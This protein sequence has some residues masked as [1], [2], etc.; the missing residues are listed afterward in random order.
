MAHELMAISITL[1]P[2]LAAPSTKQK[3][4]AHL[5]FAEQPFVFLCRIIAIKRP[6]DAICS[7]QFL[8]YFYSSRNIGI[9]AV[10][11]LRDFCFIQL[12]KG[13]FSFFKRARARAPKISN[14]SLSFQTNVLS[15]D[16]V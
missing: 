10:F 14:T 13:D 9:A 12:T 16:I 6:F 5:F 1:A 8:Q 4:F 7:L 2:S 15:V 3:V 11:S